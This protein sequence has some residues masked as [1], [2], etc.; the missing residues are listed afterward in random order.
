MGGVSAPEAKGPDARGKVL[1]VEDQYLASEFLRIWTEAY[2]FDVCGIATTADTA[3]DLARQHNPTHVLMDVRLDGVRDGV[4]AANVIQGEIVTRI[5]YCTGS[6]EPS[7]V[8]RINGDHPFAILFKPID[9]QLLG[10]AL[11]R[12]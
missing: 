4:D 12:P 6:S 9:P 1:I 2:G 5:I 11:M 10:Q 8:S 3:V 7:T